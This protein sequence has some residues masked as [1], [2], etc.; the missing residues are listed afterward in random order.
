MKQIFNTLPDDIINIIIDKI[1]HSPEKKIKKKSLSL[2]NFSQLCKKTYL[3]MS[4][5]NKIWGSSKTDFLLKKFSGCQRCKK[6]RIRKIYHSIRIR[7]CECCFEKITIRDYIIDELNLPV[8]V[9]KSLKFE[10]KSCWT[11]YRGEFSYKLYLRRDVNFNLKKF[12]F[13]NLK[14]FEDQK[15]ESIMKEIIE[16]DKIQL[17]IQLK[18][19]EK[20]KVWKDRISEWIN[21]ENLCLDK[22]IVIKEIDFGNLK[23]NTKRFKTYKLNVI[24]KYEKKIKDKKEK[25]EK[26]IKYE[27]VENRIK[28]K[29][30]Y[31]EYEKSIKHEVDFKKCQENTR[32]NSLLLQCHDKSVEC[33]I[34]KKDCYEAH[35]CCLIC[36]TTRR[37]KKLGLRD[38]TDAIHA[39]K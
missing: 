29:K 25:E 20:R 31:K 2:I 23:W 10:E 39:K 7:V 12:G 38:H 13:K 24:E 16:N 34:C 30:V 8:D 1:L 5:H 15:E 14:N 19:E 18:R 36:N 26:K 37:F 11:R 21:L 33:I 3:N 28:D 4:E 22:Q 32:K 6:P 35:Y 9:C 17:E 27:K